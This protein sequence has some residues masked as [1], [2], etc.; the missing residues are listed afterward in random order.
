MSRHVTS[1][2]RE[3]RVL[4]IATVAA[5]ALEAAVEALLGRAIFTT[6]GCTTTV[7][8]S[9]YRHDPSRWSVDV[10]LRDRVWGA[11]GTRRLKGS[12]CSALR[13]PISLVL[14]LMLETTEG[15]IEI[16]EPAKPVTSQ[17]PL[18]QPSAR[19]EVAHGLVLAGGFRTTNG[20][21]PGVGV[22]IHGGGGLELWGRRLSAQL[23]G[24]LW[25]PQSTR[26]SEPGGKFW[27][28]HAGLDLCPRLNSSEALRLSLC[29]GAQLGAIHGSGLGL[30]YLATAQR[31][32]A[33]VE[34]GF[35]IAVRVWEGLE[36]TAQVAAV[37]PWLR[38]RF[39]YLDQNETAIERHRP[40]ELLPLAGLGLSWRSPLKWRADSSLP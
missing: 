27:A 31:P 24:T 20:L 30:D 28:W 2:V 37:V 17:D 22:G 7:D 29:L 6:E 16:S 11:L 32:Y 25:A 5:A 19:R 15:S 35:M 8:V 34:A 18:Q 14:A 12:S 39:V 38:P 26:A 23:A 4:R 9:I 36:L 33:H 1:Q 21:L 13:G 3:G 40:G 10:S